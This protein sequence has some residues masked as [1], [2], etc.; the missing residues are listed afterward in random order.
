LS[1]LRGDIAAGTQQVSDEAALRAKGLSG[2][3]FQALVES[4]NTTA[5]HAFASGSKAQVGQL[6]SLFNQ[7]QAVTSKAGNLA[8]GVVVGQQLTASTA[9]LAVLVDQGKDIQHEL[10][11]IKQEIA[12]NTAKGKA[13]KMAAAASARTRR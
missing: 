10:T 4:G 2:A 13:S 5:I 9:H 6:Q 1:T 3:A 7:S 11:G 12:R 8:A